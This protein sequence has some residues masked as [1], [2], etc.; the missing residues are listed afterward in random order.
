[1]DILGPERPKNN[2]YKMIFQIQTK[3]AK[4]K[5]QWYSA[6]KS[7]PS[8]NTQEKKVLLVQ[9]INGKASPE[10]EDK[11]AVSGI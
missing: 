11:V 1:M 5:V 9:W 6:F 3:L 7:K 8:A 2:G 4:G 10:L